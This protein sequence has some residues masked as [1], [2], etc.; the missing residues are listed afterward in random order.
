M[1]WRL[2]RKDMLTLR[3]S[4]WFF[5]FVLL[6]MTFL[7][8]PIDSMSLGYS[9]IIGMIGYYFLGISHF[10]TPESD[11]ASH[12]LLLSL[13]VGRRQVVIAKYAMAGFWWLVAF[14][15][16]MILFLIA[17][18]I[19]GEAASFPNFFLAV[20]PSLCY[21]YLSMAVDHPL[22]CLFGHRVA[23]SVEVLLFAFMFS[24][25]VYLSAGQ[26]AGEL[27]PAAV[28]RLLIAATIAVGISWLLS[29]HIVRKKDH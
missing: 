6:F 15:A 11:R 28:F 4:S 18:A 16:G 22:Y 24:G 7:T 9:L 13:P 3:K 5:A 12:R 8:W 26:E 17:Q 2:M 23:Q 20:V 29:V 10:S 21:V 19:R 14:L 1:V 25:V 27:S